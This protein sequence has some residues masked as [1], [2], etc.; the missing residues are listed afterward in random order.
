M[1]YLDFS[2]VTRKEFASAALLKTIRTLMDEIELGNRAME[3]MV[4]A[5]K[6]L[7]VRLKRQ[8]ETESATRWDSILNRRSESTEKRPRSCQ[9]L[10]QAGHSLSGFY[11]VRG[12]QQR[13]EIV[14]C[15]F[16]N[17]DGTVHYSF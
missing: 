12:I 5:I 8:E 4:E 16:S 6:D 15:S 13:M 14:F 11:L 17:D 7:Q 1:D 9:D 2:K 3:E 10:K